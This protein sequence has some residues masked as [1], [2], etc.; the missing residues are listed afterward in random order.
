VFFSVIDWLGG[1]PVFASHAIRKVSRVSMNV[2]SLRPAR[3]YAYRVWKSRTQKPRKKI[4]VPQAAAVT[5]EVS[6]D[7]T[8]EV[9]ASGHPNGNSN[10]NADLPAGGKHESGIERLKI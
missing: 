4:V 6:R 3:E 2:I 10:G 5:E 8:I 9:H 1:T 7:K